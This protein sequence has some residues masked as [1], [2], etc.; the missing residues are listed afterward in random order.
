[1]WKEHYRIGSELI[2][3]QHQE[4]F[5]RV[6][7]FIRAVQGEESWE[8]RLDEVQSTLEF[9]KDYVVIHFRDEEALQKEIGYPWLEKHAAIHNAFREEIREF[10]QRVEREGF[11][12]EKVQEFAAKVMTWL[13]MH[14]GKEDQ[15]I[16]EYIREQGGQQ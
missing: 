1:M 10:A 14:V 4:L 9:M 7:S 3:S 12:E 8:E 13:I 2:D 16:G 6:A 11:D 5:G 15:R